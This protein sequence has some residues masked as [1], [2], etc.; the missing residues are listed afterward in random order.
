[1]TQHGNEFDEV[2]WKHELRREDA[3]RAHDEA[4][5][6]QTKT[7]EATMSSAQVAIRTGVLINGGAAVTV[8]GFIGALAG[9]GRVPVAQLS[10]IAGS[11]LWFAFGVASGTLALGLSYFTNY[12]YVER[13]ASRIRTWEH[14]YLKD[15]PTTSRWLRRAI[16]FHVAAV[17]VGLLCLGR[18]LINRR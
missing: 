9:Q 18:V 10:A 14:P 5:D 2:K 1:M 12:C 16:V 11:L 7:N 6:L 3:K 8:L 4:L 15:G 13:Q 17:I